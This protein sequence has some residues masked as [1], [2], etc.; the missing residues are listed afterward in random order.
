MGS[1]SIG[2][3]GLQ[4]PINISLWIETGTWQWSRGRWS[5]RRRVNVF[6]GDGFQLAV[7]EPA[8]ADLRT[9]A[10]DVGFACHE[11]LTGG[12]GVEGEGGGG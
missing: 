2:E 10:E 12:G 6:D 1:I 5:E 9:K 11:G 7:A 8:G 4:F 3:V